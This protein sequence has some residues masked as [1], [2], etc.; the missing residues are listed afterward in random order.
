MPNCLY[1][2]NWLSTIEIKNN[3]L[4]PHMY[5]EEL[6]FLSRYGENESI[7][8]TTPPMNSSQTVFDISIEQERIY[9]SLSIKKNSYFILY[10]HINKQI[11]KDRFVRL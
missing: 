2:P 11:N 6:E 1:V 7:L 10:M 9:K 3:I 4:S 8:V 5:T